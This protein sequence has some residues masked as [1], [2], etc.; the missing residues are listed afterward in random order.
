LKSNSSGPVGALAIT[1]NSCTAGM[2]VS[3]E[4]IDLQ[5]GDLNREWSQLPTAMRFPKTLHAGEARGIPFVL[6]PSKMDNFNAASGC[7]SWS[8]ATFRRLA[9]VHANGSRRRADRQGSG[10]AIM[11]F[12]AYSDDALSSTRGDGFNV[13]AIRIDSLPSTARLR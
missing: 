2:H 1:A 9:P 12:S 8:C 13:G 5:A 11:V 7:V 3:L 6:R 10:Q 4:A